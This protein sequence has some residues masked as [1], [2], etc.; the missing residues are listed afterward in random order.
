M[1]LDENNRYPEQDVVL[2]KMN[3]IGARPSPRTS[4]R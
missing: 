2:W 3:Q 1:H 4:L